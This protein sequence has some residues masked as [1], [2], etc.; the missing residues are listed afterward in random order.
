MNDIEKQ[1]DSRAR[2]PT[3]I[4]A[5][6]WWE[7]AKQT[8]GEAG[9][10]N[11][12]LIASGIAFNAFL[13]LI[14]LLTAVVLGYGLVASPAA[15]AEHIAYLASVLPE[16]AA[17]IIGS[18]LENMVET[19]GAATGLGMML[20]LGIALYG[21]IRGATGII[22][23]LNI[24]YG[25]DEGRPF[26]KQTGVALAI[27]VGLIVLFFMASAAIT[28]V[29]LLTEILPDAGGL[30]HQA[31]EFGLWIAAAAVVSVVVAVV[32][33]YAP[34]RENPQW[35]WLTPGSLIATS[36]WIAATLA[37]SFYV[38]NFGNYNATYGALGAVIVFLTWLY[39]SAY[40]LLL[41]AEL[42]QVLSRRA[43]K[44]EQ[45]GEEKSDSP[46]SG[47]QEDSGGSES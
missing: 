3:D 12:G 46:A 5:K 39:L 42:N 1:A 44:H 47:E 22:T 38:S 16:D 15:V 10:D 31:L 32:Y 27:T 28:L 26:L 34:N 17:E 35:R 29:N 37:F 36:V 33:A 23:A 11:L 6:G 8:W 9:E 45:V 13:A 19:A 21:A 41:G 7:V 43:G 20:A 18:Q 40:I 2:G 24:V 4:S 30:V 14:P 25:V